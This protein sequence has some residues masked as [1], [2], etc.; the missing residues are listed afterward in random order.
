MPATR[1]APPASE[2]TT[3][4]SP[5]TYTPPEQAT[6]AAP[7]AL[8]RCK[9]CCTDV[10]PQAKKC[11]ACGEWIVGTSGGFAA[12]VLRLLGWTWAFLSACT[13]ATILY[14]GTAIRDQLIFSNAAEYLTPFGI[15]L[16]VYAI[17]A[18]VLLQGLT[19]GVGLNVLARI[20]PRRP[21]WWS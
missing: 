13:A 9:Y 1:S 10:P 20:A 11:F 15:E 7:P 12:A 3:R 6:P 8:R 5:F 4:Q 18:I 21:R 17:S 19:V 16:A 14:V 2:R